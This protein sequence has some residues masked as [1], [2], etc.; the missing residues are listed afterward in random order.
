MSFYPFDTLSS[1]NDEAR[2][3]RYAEGDWIGVEHQTAG[4]GQ[5]GHSWSSQ[6]GL[7]I[8]GSLVLEPRFVA[9][10]EQFS[11]SQCIALGVVDTLKGYDIEAQIKWTNDIYVAGHK[12]AGI[13][14]E[15]SLSGGYLVR[16]I[17]GIGLNV[18][19]T[20]F[21]PELPNPTS[22]ALIAGRQFDREEV[23]ERLH[24]ALMARYEALREGGAEALRCDYHA[25][26][27]RLNREQRFRLPSGEE[28]LGKIRGVEAD[29]T[30]WV[31][32]PD[33]HKEGYLFREIEF[34]IA[35]RDRQNSD[36]GG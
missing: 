13:L 5:R 4:R 29:S 1:S 8:T 7:D 15:H 27:Y 22:M 14:I 11:I 30:L 12:V 28:F 17:A 21:D 33:G 24:A 2:D 25:H 32:H 31:E 35:G 18:N 16:T 3:P 26:L 34:V 6:A 23:L 36:L 20:A 9:V 19:R 10:R